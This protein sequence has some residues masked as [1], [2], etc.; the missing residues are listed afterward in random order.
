MTPPPP[1]TV[2]APPTSTVVLAAVLTIPWA[3]DAELT[4]NGFWF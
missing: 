1:L 4:A 2:V 3:G